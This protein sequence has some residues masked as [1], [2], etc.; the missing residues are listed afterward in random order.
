MRNILPKFA[1]AAAFLV[2]VSSSHAALTVI[3]Q[4]IFS[5][6]GAW[7]VDIDGDS[8]SDLGPHPDTNGHTFM[9]FADILESQSHINFETFVSASANEN[10]AYYNNIFTAAPSIVLQ[11]A[12]GVVDNADH[13]DSLYPSPPRAL[14]FHGTATVTEGSL[15][16]SLSL[17]GAYVEPPTQGVAGS[18]S[19]IIHNDSYYVFYYNFGRIDAGASVILDFTGNVFS[20][21]EP[22]TTALG[23]LSL[24]ALISG[25]KRR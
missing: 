10:P 24:S 11:P 18:R 5:T 15:S 17:V 4:S 21:P 6:P 23:L 16:N 1:L 12:A 7:S 25:R 19:G 13:S 22:S 20:I 14:L 2:S 3:P 9:Y 8:I